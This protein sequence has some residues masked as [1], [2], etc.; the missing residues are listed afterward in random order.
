MRSSSR[1]CGHSGRA[2]RQEVACDSTATKSTMGSTSVHELRWQP[3][4]DHY[5]VPNDR[6]QEDHMGG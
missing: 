4:V 6:V 2:V 5:D 1:Q 3:S